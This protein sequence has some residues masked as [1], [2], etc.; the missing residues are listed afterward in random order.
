MKLR[1]L[2]VKTAALA[3]VAAVALTAAPAAAQKTVAGVAFPQTLEA[4]GT[5]LEL[6]GA[7]LRERFT[8]DV[9]A[10]GLY[11]QT[12]TQSAKEAVSSDQPKV[13]RMHMLRKLSKKQVADAI[14]EGF[15][16]NSE[17]Q[18]P[19]LQERLDTLMAALPDLDKGDQLTLTY[20]PGKGTQLSAKGGKPVVIEGKDFSDALVNVWLGAK[21]VDAGVKK[22]LLAG[23]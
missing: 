9:Y 15:E 21:P 16:K 8:V 14:R 22:G 18:L 10:V 2:K 11:L 3:V 13:I 5:T 1:E 7:G 20:L 23:R 19:K 17:A 4:Q 6:N 12:P